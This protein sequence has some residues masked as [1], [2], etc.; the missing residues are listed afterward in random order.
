MVDRHCIIQ[1]R[2]KKNIILPYVQEVLSIFMA[3][4]LYQNGQDFLNP[5]VINFVREAEKNIF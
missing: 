1:E 2:L 4:C 5:R 3:Y